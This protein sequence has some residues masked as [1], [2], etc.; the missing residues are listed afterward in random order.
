M[1]PADLG[2]RERL[3]DLMAGFY[4]ESGYVL[5]RSRAEGAFTTLLG[6]P[7]LGRVWLIEQDRAVV[8]YIVVTFVFA[9]EHGGLAAWVDDLYVEP[10]ARGAG[11]GS[12]ALAAV[13]EACAAL[14]VRALTVEVGRDNAA[15]QAVYRSAGMGPIDRRLMMVSLADPLHEA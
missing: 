4:A 12:A 7:R 8:G 10:H 1:R 2:D 9:M 11:L 14:G 3:L 6:D 15:A 5:D 13:R